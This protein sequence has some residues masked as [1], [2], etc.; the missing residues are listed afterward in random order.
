M[1]PFLRARVIIVYFGTS[2]KFPCQLTYDQAT[3]QT[4]VRPGKDDT[5]N[6]CYTDIPGKDL[7]EARDQK[8][9]VCHQWVVVKILESISV[10]D[11]H[12][13]SWFVSQC[14]ILADVETGSIDWCT[15]KEFPALRIDRSID[16][17]IDVS[18]LIFVC[19]VRGRAICVARCAASVTSS[20]R[21][22]Q[23]FW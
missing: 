2:R 15:S 13:W 23:T 10:S 9:A 14:T 18:L 17:Y 11:K 6:A 16:R 19:C 22:Q 21:R 5:P 8:E 3:F 7:K 12:P 20:A 1:R 4:A